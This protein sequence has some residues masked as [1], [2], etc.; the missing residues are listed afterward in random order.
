[1]TG[2]LRRICRKVVNR[3]KSWRISKGIYRC[4]TGCREW[5]LSVWKS[6]EKDA[7]KKANHK[8]SF[9]Q[10]L[11]L[12]GFALTTMLGVILNYILAVYAKGNQN[13]YLL[14]IMVT[15][16]MIEVGQPFLNFR[17][18]PE[19]SRIYYYDD[20]LEKNIFIYFRQD[21]NHCIGGDAN[22]LGECNE[23]FLVSNDKIEKHKLY[24][25]SKW[26]RGC[27]NIDNKRIRLQH[28]QNEF[29][30]SDVFDKIKNDLQS[31]EVALELIERTDF[32]VKTEEKKIYYVLPDGTNGDINL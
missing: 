29:I 3:L 6:S 15:I 19:D 2:G 26:E 18:T 8:L 7:G 32:Y 17:V 1:M 24:S 31:K 28:E 10:Q 22:T 13:V 12:A 14:S 11:R 23:L 9:S 25:I 20:I 4:Y 5:L 30:M 21:E 27:V 16:L